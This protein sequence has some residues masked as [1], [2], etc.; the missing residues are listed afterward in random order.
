MFEGIQIYTQV[1]LMPAFESFSRSETHITPGFHGKYFVTK[2]QAAKSVCCNSV[3]FAS[4]R[5]VSR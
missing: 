2:Q 1:R 4:D 5:S 3:L